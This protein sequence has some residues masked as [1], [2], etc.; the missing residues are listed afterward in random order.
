MKQKGIL[1]AAILCVA[2]AA[3]AAFAQKTTGEGEKPFVIEDSILFP[4][5]DWSPA[6]LRIVDDGPT[7][8]APDFDVNILPPPKNTSAET[9]AELD[10]LLLMQEKERERLV[11]KKIM[12]ENNL[13]TPMLSFSME[14]LYDSASH[15]ETERLLT[16]VNSEVGYFLMRE[17]TKYQRARPTQLEP[18]LTTLF[19]IPPHA[20][21]PS[22][23]AGQS[24]AVALVLA[25]L[26]PAR[27]DAYIRHA[28]DVGHRREI[29]GVHY[30]SDSAAGRIIATN[31]V[32]AMLAD[33][34]LQQTI[35]N[36]KQEF[37]TP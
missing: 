1:I 36:A 31:V 19:K 11:V 21:Y 8:L 20:A 24:H 26:D 10:A 6:L 33:P 18:K 9:R 13:P 5:E 7:V 22:G 2:L 27:K 29:A 28:Y 15:P 34:K 32:G 30:P 25:A 12:L 14:G 16:L 4:R 17:K 23:H 37:V 3:G 35:Q